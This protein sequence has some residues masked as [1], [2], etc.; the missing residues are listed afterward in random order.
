MWA[1][2]YKSHINVK[3][4][5]RCILW[6][7]Y[8]QD[9]DEVLLAVDHDRSLPSIFIC[10]AMWPCL[11]YYLACL[12]RIGRDICKW[13]TTGVCSPLFCYLVWSVGGEH[14]AP[15]NRGMFFYV[16]FP[17][18]GLL[19]LNEWFLSVCLPMGHCRSMPRAFRYGF[20]YSQHVFL[21]FDL[22]TSHISI[23]AHFFSS[24]APSSAAPSASITVTP[25]T[26]PVTRV[27]FCHIG[28]ILRRRSRIDTKLA[29]IEYPIRPGGELT[30][31]LSRSVV[32]WFRPRCVD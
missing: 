5:R 7:F 17:A 13:N 22:F 29:E 15:T 9:G 30:S 32:A 26:V 31:A 23:H 18:S 19:G 3:R 24:A 16:C 4:L 14:C 6:L 2:G 10:K 12:Q 28:A 1:S 27:H 21:V 25:L 11:W 8:V 20:I